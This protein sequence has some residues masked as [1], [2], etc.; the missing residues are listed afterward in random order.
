M[1]VGS[2]PSVVDGSAPSVVVGSG[3]VSVVVGTS[4]VSSGPEGLVRVHLGQKVLVEVS[5]T[6]EVVRVVSM[7]VRP[8]VTWVRVTGHEVTVT[9]VTMVVR[10]TSVSVAVGVSTSVVSTAVVVG[11]STSV[12]STAVVGAGVVSDAVGVV[13]T[14][15]AAVVVDWTVLAVAVVVG[16]SKP[17]LWMPMLQLAFPPLAGLG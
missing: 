11:V 17:M 15:G 10:V 7:E 1:V 9:S 6:V 16:Q 8:E 13:S 3:T 2:A 14:V 5:T 4:P 12:V